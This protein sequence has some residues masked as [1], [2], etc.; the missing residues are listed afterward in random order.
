MGRTRAGKDADQQDRGHSRPRQ[1]TLQHRSGLARMQDNPEFANL[2]SC[3]TP[4]SLLGSGRAL[5]RTGMSAILRHAAP[6]AYERPGS[7]CY[8][9]PSKSPQKSIAVQRGLGIPA[10]HKALP[11]LNG[12]ANL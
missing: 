11:N 1:G 7:R 2:E 3:I 10:R 8:R 4:S 6:Q 9:T 5:P 12:R